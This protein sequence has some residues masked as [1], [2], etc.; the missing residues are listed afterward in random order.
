M[1]SK[2]S[3][4]DSLKTLYNY[5]ALIDL[6][7]NNQ[8]E[9]IVI[10]ADTINTEQPNYILILE[11]VALSYF[12]LKQYDHCLKL[13]TKIKKNKPDYLRINDLKGDTFTKLGLFENAIQTYKTYLQT[14]KSKHKIYNKIA[15][16]YYFNNNHQ[17]AVKYYLKSIK[18]VSK[19]LEAYNNLGKI[20]IELKK[21]DL[22][23]HNI[24]KAIG[25]NPNYAPAYNNLGLALINKEENKQAIKSF[26][27]AIECDDK[28]TNSYVNLA[29]VLFEKGNFKDAIALFKE[30]FYKNHLGTNYLKTLA[31]AYSRTILN[32]YDERD[33]DLILKIL[34][35]KNL[36][37]P[38]QI[39]NTVFSIFLNYI[40]KKQHETVNTELELL[41]KLSNHNLFMYFF[42][43]FVTTNLEI[44][45]VFTKSRKFILT[46]KLYDTNID[47]IENFQVTLAIQNFLNGFIHHESKEE[48]LL[49]KNLEKEIALEI[50]NNIFNVNKILCLAS[51]RSL[52]QYPFLGQ[53]TNFTSLKQ[54]TD[55]HIK[56]NNIEAEEINKINCL[57]NVT[58]EVSV[59]VKRQYEENPYPVW[60]DTYLYE[61]RYSIYDYFV[62][63]NLKTDK[64]NMLNGEN[65]DIL[66]AGSGTGQHA[67]QSSSRFKNS[68][69]LAIDLSCKS[70]AYAIRK[71]NEL[72][73]NNIEFMIADILDL[74]KLNKRFTIIESCGV[75]HHLENPLEGWSEL[76]KKLKPNGLMRIGL[77]SKFG[78]RDV[79][80]ARDV[81]KKNKLSLN[82]N[83]MLSFRQEILESD[84]FNLKKLTNFSDFYSMN[85]YRDLIFHF[86]EHHFDLIEINEMINHL[87]LTFMGFELKDN[88]IKKSFEES[89]SNPDD[90]YSLK[91]WD[92]YERENPDT[93][94]NMYDFWVRL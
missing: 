6:Y 85:E 31:L 17:T 80:K 42:K 24:N 51:Y 5:E 19:N 73:V 20:F 63:N 34:K 27:K 13:I 35:Y 1:F 57:T 69:V 78:R 36:I 11:I 10:N 75:L 83:N 37:H 82:K 46:N 66:I 26:L 52:Q 25:L 89:F 4:K 16:V 30:A 92:E 9:A 3:T 45:K 21:P 8:Q 79:K 22:A 7:K 59:L 67:I 62:K 44:E 33:T 18:A 50:N 88:Y 14:S 41:T 23:I 58:D 15:N 12:D 87:G 60:E 54:V 29:T 90:Y 64:I 47:D 86:K 77:Y 39:S 70:T 91:L 38:A 76:V 49:I 28:Y 43:M 71:A 2:L 84:K 65:N 81:I 94:R 40:N 93:F 55:I 53:E 32:D 61:N 56:N 48:K 74:N 72:D 68:N